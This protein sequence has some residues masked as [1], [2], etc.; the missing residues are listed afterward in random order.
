MNDSQPRRTFGPQAPHL[1]AQLLRSSLT[2]IQ[3]ARSGPRRRATIYG[4]WRPNA[5]P[6]LGITHLLH[7]EGA[8]VDHEGGLLLA[9]L[10]AG[11]LQRDGP[12][13]VGRQVERPLGVTDVVVEVRVGGQRAQ[14]GA[15][16]VED[17]S[18]EGVVGGGRGG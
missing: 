16:G 11:E 1:A 10:A 5:S 3:W 14:D 7:A 4:T 6:R 15:A 18:L 9:V 2:H 8:V 17:L 12:A 13:D